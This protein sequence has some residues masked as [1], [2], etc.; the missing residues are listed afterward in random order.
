[1]GRAMGASPE[2]TCSPGLTMCVGDAL[3]I[4]GN[5]GLCGTDQ[6]WQ[7]ESWVMVCWLGAR[8]C[9][10]LRECVRVCPRT[11]GQPLFSPV[12]RALLSC[13]VLAPPGVVGMGG[14]PSHGRAWRLVLVLV[15]VPLCLSPTRFAA[16]K[17]APSADV[18]CFQTTPW[19]THMVH[20]L[21][22]HAVFCGCLE[23]G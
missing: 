11:V 9:R 18:G 2:A 13:D 10:S 14:F 5:A 17:H 4:V 23:R 12:W 16:T 19:C 1:M 22:H 7:G 8:N 3:M 21:P 20:A 6:D 15:L